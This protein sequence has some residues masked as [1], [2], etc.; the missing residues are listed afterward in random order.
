MHFHEIKHHFSETLYLIVHKIPI[1]LIIKLILWFCGVR[2]MLTCAAKI[3][4]LVKNIP[5]R[6][7]T[8]GLS[9]LDT[10]LPLYMPERSITFEVLVFTISEKYFFRN[11]F[12]KSIKFCPFWTLFL[13]HK[14]LVKTQKSPFWP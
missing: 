2:K 1:K 8:L 10:N 11:I 4:C 3:P 12:L 13:Y 7:F 9:K 5:G 6:P 14:I